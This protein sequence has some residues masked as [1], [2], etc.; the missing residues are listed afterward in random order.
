MRA[1]KET[2]FPSSVLPSG[3]V[4]E[5]YDSSEGSTALPH[6]WKNIFVGLID[7]YYNIY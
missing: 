3:I 4:I 1:R 7:Y 2:F 5:E 6:L